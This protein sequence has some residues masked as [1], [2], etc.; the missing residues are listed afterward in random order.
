MGRRQHNQFSGSHK[1]CLAI[2]ASTMRFF[3]ISAF[4]RLVK[5]KASSLLPP[6]Y[7]E[8]ENLLCREST[9]LDFYTPI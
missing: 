3:E 9:K 2:S 7:G 5:L 6:S 1:I 4:P 8:A